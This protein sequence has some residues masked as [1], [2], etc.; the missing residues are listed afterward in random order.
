MLIN[1][2]KTKTMIFDYTDN[3][4]FTTRLS[5]NNQQIEI[6]D[7]TKLLGTVLSNNLSWDLI[8]AE[9]VKNANAWMQLLRK[10]ASFGTSLHEL[11]DIYILYRVNI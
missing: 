8:T 5:N 7:S 10:V 3:Y 4:E 11:K 2:K 9:I 6:M 1:E